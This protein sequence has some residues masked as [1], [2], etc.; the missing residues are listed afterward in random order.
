VPEIGERLHH[1]VIAAAERLRALPESGRVVPERGIARLREVN[2]PPFRIVYRVD[3]DKVR[4]VRVWRS[5]RRMRTPYDGVTDK[6]GQVLKISLRVRNDEQ[7]GRGHRNGTRSSGSLDKGAHNAGAPASW[8][9]QR[10]QGV[11]LCGLRLPMS[12]QAEP[13]RT[14]RLRADACGP[15]RRL[16]WQSR[17]RAA[18]IVPVVAL[19]AAAGQRGAAAAFNAGFSHKDA[20]DARKSQLALL[21]WQTLR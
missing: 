3:K 18:A 5:E 1:E 17:E 2:H 10:R 8:G 11:L 19:V 16:V 13:P 15:R 14:P 20:K 6:E 4:I 7:E 21:P 9:A 12:G